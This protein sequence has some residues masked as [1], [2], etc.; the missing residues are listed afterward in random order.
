[1]ILQ[2]PSLQASVVSAASTAGSSTPA[3]VKHLSR[4][5]KFFVALRLAEQNAIAAQVVDVLGRVGR[6]NDDQ[7]GLRRLAVLAGE[8]RERAS[9]PASSRPRRAARPSPCRSRCRSP[10]S[11]LW[12]AL[13]RTTRQT[14]RAPAGRASCS[15]IRP[16]SHTSAGRSPRRTGKKAAP[17]SGSITTRDSSDLARRQAGR[18]RNAAN[19]HDH[20]QRTHGIHLM[21]MRTSDRSGEHSDFE[22][23]Q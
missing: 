7:S 1:M 22:Q 14:S 23:S 9:R 20:Q 21:K 2:A 6:A 10:C 12:R 8:P 13:F 4:R 15:S 16:A 5:G 19:A 3:A 18:E 11:L 17:P